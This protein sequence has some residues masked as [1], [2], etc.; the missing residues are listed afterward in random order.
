MIAPH[1][2]TSTIHVYQPWY[3][4]CLEI[5]IVYGNSTVKAG[6]ACNVYYF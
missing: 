1:L 2:W 5:H 6:E 3:L 4:V